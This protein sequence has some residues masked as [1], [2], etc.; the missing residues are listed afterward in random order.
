MVDRLKDKVA[1]ITGAARGQG[2][3]MA[4]LFMRE[5]AMAVVSGDVVD[6]ADAEDSKVT[7]VKMDVTQPDQWKSVVA[8]IVA[9]HGRIDILI[10][11]AAVC[12]YE[13]ILET[14]DEQYDRVLDI[15]LKSIFLGMREVLPHM[16]R[17]QAGSIINVSSI[18]GL[19]GVPSSY[20]Y[21]AA[22]GAILNVSK[23]VAATH[24]QDG[25]RCNSLH[26]GYILSPMNEHQAPEI[27]AALIAGTVLKRPGVPIETAYAAL[28]LASDEASYVTGTSLV[29]DGGYL[30]P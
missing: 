27:N 26:P 25:V 14:T 21:Q 19:A 4:E 1:L 18:W 8:D 16:I 20:A 15:D 11:N 17:Q 9:E 28:F 30:A 23:N 6:A 5:G 3:E 29:V 2:R 13:P 24:G 7:F 22:K 12:E 10:N